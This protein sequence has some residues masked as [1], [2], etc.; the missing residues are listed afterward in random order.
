MSTV[1]MR[2]ADIAVDDI[3]YRIRSMFVGIASI[4]MVRNWNYCTIRK[5]TPADG[6]VSIHPAAHCLLPRPTPKSPVNAENPAPQ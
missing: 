1:K 6:H 2:G 4:S 5:K 3:S